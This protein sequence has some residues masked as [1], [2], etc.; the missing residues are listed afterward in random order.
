MEAHGGV[1]KHKSAL[2]HFE[3]RG[4]DQQAIRWRGQANL[5]TGL[6]ARAGV[7][8]FSIPFVVEVE[9]SHRERWKGDGHAK[10]LQDEQSHTDAGTRGGNLL[11]PFANKNQLSIE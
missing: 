7:D 4:N 3:Y 5:K 8:L 2:V 1:W 6:T 11:I 10:Q 9:P